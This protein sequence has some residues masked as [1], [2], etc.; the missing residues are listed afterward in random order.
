MNGRT[1]IKKVVAVCY[2]K[3]V[4]VAILVDEGD[5]ALLTRLRGIQMAVRESRGGGEGSP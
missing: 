5:F 3:G 2:F 4:L 1:D